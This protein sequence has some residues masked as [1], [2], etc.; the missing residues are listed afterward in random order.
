MDSRNVDEVQ[1]NYRR[2]SERIFR[3]S[4]LA[5]RDVGRIRL[6]VVTKGQPIDKIRA[7]L[8]AG[9]TELG[10]NYLEEAIPKIE[11]FKPNQDLT[12]HMIGHVQSRKAAGVCQQFGYVQSIDSLKL[13]QRMSR[14]LSDIGLQMPVLLEF[15]VSG[16]ET[17]FGFP[18]WQEAWWDQLL[19]ELSEIINQ[20]SLAIH[21]LMGMAPYS[22]NPESARPY[23][24]R[25]YRLREY[26]FHNFPEG[27][28]SELSMGM[29]ADFEIA[30]QEGATI[31]RIGEAIMGKRD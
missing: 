2:I 13:A 21:G 14:A 26:L 7:V 29:S 30:I 28:W 8:Q 27:D 10:E 9:A 23:F 16:E 6:V 20:P 5:G 11:L 18:A 19:P 31:V 1:Q 3:T 12:W 22:Q 25:L 24:Q 17:K 4:T 15:N